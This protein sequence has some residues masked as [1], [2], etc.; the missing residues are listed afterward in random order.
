MVCQ[1]RRPTTRAS[2]LGSCGRAAMLSRG[3]RARRQAP[4]QAKLRHT[5]TTPAGEGGGRQSIDERGRDGSCKPCAITLFFPIRTGRTRSSLFLGRGRR[6]TDWKASGNESTCEGAGRLGYGDEAATEN[7][8]R[9]A[10]G[11]PR[12]ARTPSQERQQSS[13][14]YD[15]VLRGSITSMY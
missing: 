11:D 10:H 2:F 12:P 7:G 5:L 14:F 8:G 13:F 15:L 4:P 6:G 9:T 1:P 3:V